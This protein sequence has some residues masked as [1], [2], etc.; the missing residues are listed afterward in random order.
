MNAAPPPRRRV[1]RVRRAE[2]RPATPEAWGRILFVPP[3]LLLI[4]FLVSL[5]VP[6]GFTLVGLQ[7]NPYNSILIVF[8]IPA[9]LYWLQ[10]QPRVLVTDVLMLLFILWAGLAIYHNQGSSRIIFI[11][12]QSV[13]LFGAY[14]LGRV[15]VRDAASYRLM[16]T[17]LFW[18]LVFLFPFALVELLF[19]RDLLAMALG[20]PGGGGGGPGG[21]RLGMRRVASVFP[22]PILFGVFCSIMISNFFYVFHERTGT[23]LRRTLLAMAMT[24]M[25]LS[26]GP[27]LSQIGQLMLIAWERVFRFFVTKWYV[28]VVTAAT[29][30]AIFQLAYPG[31]LVGFVINNLAFNPRTGL[32]RLEILQYGTLTVLQHPMFGIGLAPWNGPWWRPGSVDNYW[33]VTALRYGLPGLGLFWAAI[34]WHAIR[35]I[36]RSR[37][38]EEAASYR[39]GYVFAAA[40]AFFALG[41]VHIW[42]SVAIF[43]LFYIGAGAWFYTGDAA[44]EPEAPHERLRRQPLTGAPAA[45]L[46]AALAAAPAPAPQ[47]T[48][49][50]TRRVLSRRPIS[51]QD[52]S[53]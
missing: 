6:V 23:R 24:F 4:F 39:K 51:R 31:G 43:I 2:R 26:S 41:A 48:T 19:K 33:M 36:G 30:I 11:L 38:T 9:F 50:G 22:H 5:I 18:M 52:L 47:R 32:G 21:T 53:R 8:L 17:V 20:Q 14:V 49:G 16:F 28:M 35:I 12:N 44:R 13:T 10:H 40:G 25:S 15:L 46:A 42:G 37:L 29:T 3:R 27:N 45:A 1:E 34:A 7:L